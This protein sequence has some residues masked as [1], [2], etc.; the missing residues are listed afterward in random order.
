MLQQKH[1]TDIIDMMDLFIVGA[2]SVGGFLAYH[3]NEMGQY[4]IRGFL[5]DDVT[6][7]GEKFYDIPV[8]GGLDFVSNINTKFA[9]AIAV[10][11]PSSKQDI[12]NKLKKNQFVT[13]PSFIHPSSWIGAK[14]FIDEGCIIYPGVII[15]FETVINSFSTINMNSNIGHNCILG[16][17]STLS[18]G[19]NLG[20]F[21]T[22]GESSFMG[23]GASTIQGI[24]IGNNSIIGA[25]SVVIKNV[26]DNSKVIGNPAKEIVHKSNK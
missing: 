12:V 5:D 19:V 1:L 20:G 11:D 7:N 10:A 22:I 6:K 2:G 18:P 21:T 13:F 14:V 24:N 17:F 26:N 15:N 9:V 23:I 25:M 8:L 3:A 4:S 16:E